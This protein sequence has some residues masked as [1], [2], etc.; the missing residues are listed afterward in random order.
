MAHRDTKR[1]TISHKQRLEV[2]QADG[3]ICGYCAEPKRRKPTSLVVDHVIPVYLH[4][5]LVLPFRLNEY[6]ICAN[7]AE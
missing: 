5:K 4:D 7:Y 1:R 3:Y 2:L 6:W